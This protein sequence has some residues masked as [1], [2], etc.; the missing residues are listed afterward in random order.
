[1]FEKLLNNIKSLFIPHV[2]IRINQLN[3]SKEELADA[4]FE[5]REEIDKQIEELLSEQ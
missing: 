2:D 3:L 1:M 4:L 5:A